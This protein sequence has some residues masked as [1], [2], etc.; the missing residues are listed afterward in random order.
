MIKK[1]SFA[2]G[3]AMVAALVSVYSPDALEIREF[4]VGIRGGEGFGA[5]MEPKLIELKQNDTLILRVASYQKGMMHIHGY[6]LGLMVGPDSTAVLEFDAATTGRFEIMFH[7]VVPK[8][9]TDSESERQHGTAGH[10][11]EEQNSS[12]DSHGS[13]TNDE[14]T[15]GEDIAHSSDGLS[16]HQSEK[17]DQFLGYLQVLPR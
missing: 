17:A 3:L 5:S 11:D 8:I 6:D 9:A 16:E 1:I 10:Q 2:L 12:H 7:A 13:H 14:T 4:E 15:A